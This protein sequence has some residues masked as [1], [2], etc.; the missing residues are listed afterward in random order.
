MK[1]Q[2]QS[3]CKHPNGDTL[4]EL[5]LPRHTPW[6]GMISIP[7]SGQVIPNEL[8]PYL[9]DNEW[10]LGQDVDFSV[11]KLI[12]RKNLLENGVV[13]LKANIHR[14]TCDLNRP[15]EETIFNWKQNSFGIPLICK[16][17][18]PPQLK[19]L[20]T[21]YHKPYFTIIRNILDTYAQYPFSF[22][23]LHSMPS[24]P[25]DYHLKKNPHQARERPDF[26]LSNLRGKSC[27][28]QYI[29]SMQ[30]KLE[31]YGYDVSI[32][33]PYVGGYIT[34]FAQSYILDNIQIEIKRG[35]YMDEQTRELKPDSKKLKEHLTDALVNQM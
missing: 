18:R 10:A 24:H 20:S 31:V 1:R 17:P 7:H 33:E 5:D 11:D 2:L 6:R 15:P 26:C 28:A 8:R 27:S 3:L 35:I 9:T 12:D 19:Q 25:T 32:N 21:I 22:I 34:Q 14:T 30:K 13:I 23:D 29:E 16:M 4:F